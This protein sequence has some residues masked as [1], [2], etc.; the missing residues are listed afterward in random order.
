MSSFRVD[1]DRLKGLQTD[2]RATEGRLRD[3]TRT[4]EAVSPEQLGGPELDDACAHFSGEWQYGIGQ[5]AKFAGS[6]ADRLDEGIKV[7]SETEAA[8]AAS[9]TPGSMTPGGH[10]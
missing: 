5:I 2:L 7:Y 1:V 6:V 10:G 4:L 3:V 8:V 9:M